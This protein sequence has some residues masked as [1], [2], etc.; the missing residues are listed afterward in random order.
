MIPIIVASGCVGIFLYLALF[1]TVRFE[2]LVLAFLLFG[3]IVGNRGFAQL[4]IRPN[5]PLYLGE[6]GMLACLSFIAVRQTLTRGQLIPKIPLSWAII[7]FL[8][9]GGIRLY[10]DTVL[11]NS[12][13]LV[14]LAIRDSAVVYYA[15][16]FFIAYQIGKNESA[17]KFVERVM[18]AGFFV[19]I[20]VAVLVMWSN[21][22]IFNKLT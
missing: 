1:R 13:S 4:S 21:N 22:T 12:T 15:L 8:L 10:F 5:S 19:L 18:M 7:V 3:Y 9:I 2:A 6:L 11:P 14:T 16:F 20:P 17:R